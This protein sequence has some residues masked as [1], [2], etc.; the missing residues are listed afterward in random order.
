MQ[1]TKA[2]P[3]TWHIFGPVDPLGPRQTSHFSKVG[4]FIER[5]VFER[6]LRDPALPN[7]PRLNQATVQVD[8]LEVG[9]LGG[10]RL[11]R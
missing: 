5:L 6:Q 9:H 11:C 3:Q 10:C 8:K 4:I 1:A 7:T 2:F